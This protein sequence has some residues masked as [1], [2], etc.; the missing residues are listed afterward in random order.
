[1]T[2]LGEAALS[3]APIAAP[4][5]RPSASVAAGVRDYL[6]SDS[7]RAYQTV[8]GLLWLLDGALQFQ[9]FMYSN[10]FVH[11]LKAN[12]AGQPHWLASTI[13]WAANT[14]HSNLA[15]FNTLF[16]L[17]QVAIGLGLLYR[18]T[19]K[20][21]LALSIAWAFG[22]WWFGEGFGMLFAGAASPL[23][24]APGAVVLY[25]LVA[26]LV[27][28]SAR[29]AGLLS[30]G[31]ARA[32]WGTLW[33]GMAYLWLLPANSGPNGT[34]NAIMMAPTGM[35]VH[36][37]MAWLSRIDGQAELAAL[38]HGTAIAL[39]L[40]GVSASIALAVWAN[41]RPVAFLSLAIVVSL[42]YWVIGQSFGGIGFTG[43]ATDP[44]AG[45]LFVLLALVM[46]SLTA[47]GRRAPSRAAPRPAALV[48]S[49]TAGVAI[50]LVGTAVGV[51]NAEVRVAAPAP[52]Q[53]VAYDSPFDG[54]AISPPVPAP[55]V[56]LRNY[57]GD[58]ITL[59]TY[60]E[61]GDTVLLTFLSARCPAN[62]AAIASGLH[63]SV[64]ALPAASARRLEV[65]V[66]STNP[67]RD[68]PRTVGGFLRRYRLVGRT[69]Y[70][71][72]S[73]VQLR[74]VWREW[75]IST[76]SDAVDLSGP[77][78]L[79]YG[80]APTGA[81]MTRYSAFFTPQQILHDVKRLQTL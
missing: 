52:P 48:A 76:S 71:T 4:G 53:P 73:P 51:T 35:S 26:L 46:Y 14:A 81:V 32:A 59:S 23:T 63:R 56:S 38:G 34:F 55:P 60:S 72:G 22:V 68:N 40:S 2:W 80:I 1:V 30:I 9:P 74:P 8:L 64:A 17:V 44:N 10:G 27:W 69:Q 75:G 70:L 39:V 62:C 6:A 77:N 7:R 28:P 18:R 43:N 45:P 31:G 65:V 37:G 41:W 47:V 20:P 36:N 11:Q 54:L 33:L 5:R 42:G 21:A 16:A 25:A 67:G 57:H 13:D 79:V 50:A 49:L 3:P 12:A 19:V 15:A 61:R 66:I 58:Q 78:A 24:G 29:P